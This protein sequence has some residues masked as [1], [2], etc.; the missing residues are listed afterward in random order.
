MQPKK[1]RLTL[2][3]AIKERKPQAYSSL[4]ASGGLEPTLDEL[5]A[6]I[7]QTSEEIKGATLDRLSRQDSPHFQ[8]DPVK[9]AQEIMMRDLEADRTALAQAIEQIDSL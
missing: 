8:P 5:M 2:E 9:R 3:N 7:V 4:K 6:G 1:L